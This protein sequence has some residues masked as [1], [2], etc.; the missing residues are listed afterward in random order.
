MA[1]LRV[2]PTYFEHLFR[3]V[4]ET[5]IASTYV[6]GGIATPLMSAMYSG[7]TTLLGAGALGI[8]MISYGIYQG[9]KAMPLLKRQ[10]NLRTNKKKF[11]HMQDLRVLNQLEL[12]K[13]GTPEE[14]KKNDI[15]KMY[16][17]DG[18]VWGTE[19]ANRA[20]QVMDMDSGFSEV[21]IPFYMRSIAKRRSAD[22]E[23]LGGS[24]WIH[25]MGD[26][27]KQM[28]RENNWFGH[29]C[30][31]G[32]VGTGKTTLLKLMAINALHMGNVLIILD[33]KNDGDWKDCIRE[34]M[35]YLGM[36]DKF[37]HLHPSSPST[38]C[39]IPLLKNYTRITE[40]AARIAP[41][42]GG[43][44]DG[45][46]FQDFAYGIIYATSLAFNYL[47]E[48]IRLTKI[49]QVIASDRRGLALRVMDK[50]YK[51]VISDEYMAQLAE[52]LR[53]MGDSP[54]EQL[55]NY[56]LANLNT[57]N[58]NKVI[59]KMIEFALHD[60]GHYVKMVTGLRPVLTALTADPL[61]D[62]FSPIDNAD[63]DDPRPIID[64][65]KIMETGG[66]LYIS[67]DSLTDG[68]TASFISR[69]VL[70]EASAV[71]GDRYNQGDG[72][73]RRVT[74]ANDEV[75]ASIENND[76]L[77]NMLAQGRAASMEMI[78]ATQTISDIA[79][80]TDKSTADRFLGLCNNF[81][82]MRTTDPLTQ[83][84]VSSQFA[85]A[86]VTQQQVRTGT[87]RDTKSSLMD[88]SIGH[89]ETLMKTREASFPPSLLGDLPTLQYVA[90]LADGKKLKMRLPI[91]INPVVN[92]EVAEWA[93]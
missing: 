56:Y 65:A 24:P 73:A 15:R 68:I 21:N 79:A 50:Y 74:I 52:E 8:C 11:L 85:E 9:Y 43:T 60:D 53:Q 49:Q 22:T 25:G 3:P 16:I 13:T 38:S 89:Q 86:S 76:S 48:P 64:I 44:G 35:A 36:G 78:L 82:S 4:Y 80:K 6:A 23:M 31:T 34:E 27:K 87:A 81:I 71:A 14:I 67:L 59:D 83:E 62:L 47:G 58:H 51:E 46:V 70:A 2:D 32:N 7:G 30:I 12:R 55:A 92:E 91:L 10:L 20:Y 28:I 41:L 63:L 75:H 39:R 54:L 61:D 66:C 18:F 17:G 19:H 77:M 1:K 33:P 90:R 88:F 84:Y 72:R 69:L 42:M 37:Y 26:E 93:R 29:T 57:S 5:K 45:K 40:I